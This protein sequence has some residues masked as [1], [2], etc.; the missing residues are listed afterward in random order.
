MAAFL[1]PFRMALL[2]SATLKTPILCRWG[3]IGRHRGF[4][5]PR[6][7]GLGSSSLPTGTILS[8]IESQ[9]S[10]LTTTGSV[11]SR[12]RVGSQGCPPRQPLWTPGYLPC[13]HIG[14]AAPVASSA[15]DHLSQTNLQLAAVAIS[16]RPGIASIRWRS[17]IKTARSPRQR[18]S[19]PPP[20]C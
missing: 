13:E 16:D 12:G 17:P 2:Y 6:L 1:L 8:L 20:V 9:R 19:S 15:H 18:P 10:G 5:I 7:H 4:K 14:L 3:G 11:A